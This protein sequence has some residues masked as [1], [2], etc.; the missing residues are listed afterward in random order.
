MNDDCDQQRRSLGE[1]DFRPLSAF[2]DNELSLTEREA[3]LVRLKTEP[4]AAGRVADYRA[5]KAALTAIFRDPRDHARCIVVCHRTPWWQL[6]GLAASCLA[7]GVALGSSTNCDQRRST[8]AACLRR[9][10]E[11]RKTTMV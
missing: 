10:S 5:Q 11:G 3:T 2:A 9:R 6:A 1:P 7:M 8:H 4:G